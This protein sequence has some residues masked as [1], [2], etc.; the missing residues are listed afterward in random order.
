[1]E[2]STSYGFSLVPT[3]FPAISV[4]FFAVTAAGSSPRSPSRM[5]PPAVMEAFSSAFTVSASTSPPASRA[6]S[7]PAFTVSTVMFPPAFAVTFPG[8]VSSSV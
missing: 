3:S 1:M 7:F 4:M 2:V 5:E 8:A 6:A